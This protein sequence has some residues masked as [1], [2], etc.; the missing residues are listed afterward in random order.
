MEFVKLLHSGIPA[1]L[2]LAYFS[3]DHYDSLTE[4]QRQV[5]L[6]QWAR[7]PLVVAAAADFNKGAWQDLD[8]D[9]RLQIALDKHL[10]ELAHFLYTHTFDAAE[11]VEYKKMAD[12]RATLMEHLTAAEGEPDGPFQRMMRELL[13]GKIEADGPPQIPTEPT[14][15]H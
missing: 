7:S 1:T 14:T 15:K 13:A 6:A 11:G 5:W 9:A 3:A 10:A 12:A 2:C 8:K 4:K